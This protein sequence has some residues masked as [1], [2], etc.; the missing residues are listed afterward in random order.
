MEVVVLNP[1]AVVGPY[2]S[3]PSLLGKAIQ[4]L[5]NKKV[6]M[7]ISGGFDFCDVR[8]VASG[9]VSAIDR[10]RNG[11][12]YLLSGKWHSLDDMQKIILGIKG[13]NRGVP[14]LPAWTGYLGLPFT[15]MVAALN[16]QEP[17]YTR[18]SI[19]T[20]IQGNKNISSEKA[21]RDLGYACRPFPETIA[22]TITWFKE[23][24]HL[25]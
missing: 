6:P 18:E 17:L 25:L 13:D 19:I 14:V 8:D 4:D 9:I 7:L 22:D 24:G 16:R 12:S 20:L 2:D 3:R 11:H 21:A 1:T 15:R 10:G 5:Y 23:T